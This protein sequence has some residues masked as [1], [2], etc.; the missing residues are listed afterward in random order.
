[1]IDFEYLNLHKNDFIALTNR[2][3]NRV[4]SCATSTTGTINSAVAHGDN[5]DQDSVSAGED[6]AGQIVLAL[7]AFRKLKEEYSDYK[8]GLLLIDE[9]DAGL[10]PAAQI[11]LIDILNHECHDLNLQVIMTSHSPTL[12]EYT[13]EQS[14]KFRRRF[15]TVYLSDTYGRVQIME[16]MSWPQINADIHTRTVSLSD[17]VALPKVNV[18]FEDREGLGVFK[19]IMKRQA[20][21]KFLNLLDV[22]LGCS[23]YIQLIQK[24]ITEFSEKS[25]ICLDADVDS[26]GL[27]SIVLL[28]G[29]LPPDQLI[30]EYL[31]NLP[32]SHKIW[33][34]PLQFTRQVLTSVASDIIQRLEIKGDTIDLKAL[35]SRCRGENVKMEKSSDERLRKLFKA[36]YQNQSFQDF[37]KQKSEYNPWHHWINENKQECE[38][39]KS[40]FIVRLYET[41]TDTYGVESSKLAFLEK[42]LPIASGKK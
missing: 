26:K 3:L 16:D 15:K 25:I 34:N 39:F 37:L 40:R 23:N 17:D 36:F 30:F 27:S 20:I 1:V 12:I 6:N 4:S 28:P 10:F 31:Y 41:L 35:I 33:R 32:P 8:G 14:Q 9:A 29:S 42:A 38:I 13:Y 2:L 24:K 18:Y 21:N 5:Y 11:K 7:M 19:E 22:T